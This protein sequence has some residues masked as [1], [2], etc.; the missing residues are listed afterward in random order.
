M[1]ILLVQRGN[2]PMLTK[3][4]PVVLT[5]SS[6]NIDLTANMPYIPSAGQTLKSNY[7]YTIAP[8]GKGA[9]A[10]FAVSRL[11]GESV[12][13]AK[14]GCDDYADKLMEMYRKAHINVDY[15]TEDP[16]ERTGLALVMVEKDGVNRIVTY[17]GANRKLSYDDTAYAME[18]CPDAL[19]LQMEIETDTIID[20]AGYAKRT[21]VPIIVD[22]GPA[23]KDFPLSALGPVEIFSPNEE[24]TYIYT[25]I[26]P[27]N[28]DNCLKACMALAKLIKA[29]Y[30]ILKLGNRGVFFYDGLYHDI[31][32]P[33]KVKAVDTTS[34]GDVFTAAL[35]VE[36]LRSGDIKRA[37]EYA[38]IAGALTVTR[39]GSFNSVPCH[40]DVREFATERKLKIKFD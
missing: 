17:P 9:N 28:K 40:D 7:G 15:I 12:F 25:G 4:R 38:N 19:I 21:E 33:H 10:A 23:S 18:C 20:T 14:L 22:A 34:A 6:A 37:C 26:R 13:C 39:H 11:G 5:V 27:T 36:Y 3:K 1:I 30:Y 16:E 32:T 31:I 8:G 2:K 35:A 24:E 29:K